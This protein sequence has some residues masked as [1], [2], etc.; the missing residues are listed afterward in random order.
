MSCTGLLEGR[1]SV[2][3]FRAEEVPDELI[4]KA[5]ETARWAPSAKNAQPWRVVVIK[6]R[7]VLEKLGSV[8]PGAA[9]LKGCTVAFA[10]IVKP[11]EAPVT[12]LV[13]GAIFATYLWLS[14]H[15]HGIGAVW[16]N[17]LRKPEYAQLV[18]AEPGEVVVA[19][20][21]AGFPAEQPPPK[22]RKKLEEMVSWIR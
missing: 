15:A 8:A 14:L 6:S 13:D 2:R 9:P 7:E 10:V 5:L 18:G 4:I 11:E 19:I 1:R 12:F 21:A 17:A 3:K 16:I 22:P 20:L